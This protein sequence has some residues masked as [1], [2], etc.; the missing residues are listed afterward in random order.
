MPPTPAPVLCILREVG[1]VGVGSETLTDCLVQIR[2]VVVPQEIQ[3]EDR[4]SLPCLSGA[5][6]RSRVCVFTELMSLQPSREPEA[7]LKVHSRGPAHERCSQHG[8]CRERLDPVGGGATS[9]DSGSF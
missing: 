2:C 5:P 4:T 9:T 3:E 8:A 6:C 7:G 1:F